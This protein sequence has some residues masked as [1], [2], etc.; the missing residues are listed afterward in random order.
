MI[1]FYMK[2]NLESLVLE[3]LEERLNL[4]CTVVYK[5][6]GDYND[7]PHLGSNTPFRIIEN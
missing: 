1:Y 7:W 4:V 5:S 2:N 6:G 3:K